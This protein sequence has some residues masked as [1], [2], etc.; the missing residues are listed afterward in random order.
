MYGVDDFELGTKFDLPKFHTVNEEGKFISG[1]G[2]LEGR[3]VKEVD[4]NGKPT[5]AVDIVNDLT[6]RGLLFKKENYLHS[7]PHCW[8]CDTP[9]LYYARTSWYF[10]MSKLRDQLVAANQE[11]NWEP[12]HVKEGRFGEWLDGIKDW[13]ISRDRYWGTPLPVWS[14]ESGK[15]VVI[16]GLDDLKKYIKKSGNSYFM[17]RHGESEK[18]T[19]DLCSSNPDAP[20]PL[21]EKGRS[22]AKQT[23]LGLVDSRITK[24]IASPFVRTRETAEIVADILGISKE[25]IVYDPSIGELH[26]GDFDGKSKS[27]YHAWHKESNAGFSTQIP[28]G[29]SI[30]EARNR[31]GQ[32]LYRIDKQY[33]NEN[34]LIVTHGIFLESM[35]S[36]VGG[37]DEEETMRRWK[38]DIQSPG[39]CKKYDFVPLPHNENYALDFHKPYIDE[40][41]LE[42][43]GESLKRTPEVMDVWFDSG[44]MPIAQNHELGGDVNFDP[45]PA[46]YIAEGMD[47]TRGWFYTMHAISNMLH[48]KPSVAYKN[49]ICMGLLMDAN[50]QKMSKSKGN[51]VDPW[52]MFDKYG[53]DVVRFWFYSVNQPGETKN[54]DEKGLD[55]VNKK[56]FNLLRNVVAFYEMFGTEED[57]ATGGEHN[58]YSSP[59]VLDIWILAKL[60]ELNKIATKG[61]DTYQPLEPARALR[62]FIGELSTWY[63]RR[64]RDRFKSDDISDRRFALRTTQ[65]VLRNLSLMMAPFTPFVAEEVFQ[66]TK[67]SG[68]PESVHLGVWI[69]RSGADFDYGNI[70]ADM[71]HVRNLVTLGLE[72]RQK[73]NVKVRQPLSKLLINNPVKFKSLVENGSYWEEYKMIILEELNIKEVVIFY[74]GNEQTESLNPDFVSIDSFVTQDLKDEGDMRELVRKIQDM[75]KEAG[76]EPKDRVKVSLAGNEPAWFGKFKPEISQ[77]VGAESISWGGEDGVEKVS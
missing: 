69:D 52:T 33:S 4:E 65:L 22:D 34:I 46:D 67:W 15:R 26:Y 10:G 38:E 49:A 72:A 13:A 73:A 32:A 19:R 53:A 51:V 57:L 1:T 68:D 5:L 37:W 41:E 39:T 60:D 40:V 50:G 12:D 59:N 45:A 71:D 35:P 30:K 36:L 16:G 21:T 17:M 70:L 66:K 3:Y 6:A 63:I 75:R 54:F 25:E 47:Q 42:L 27:E 44:C 77:T 9:L 29:E 24:I 11:I 31:V 8:R 20:L 61:L 62:E 56:V 74:P 48:D 55:E 64:S 43:D 58:P 76:L 18:N 2:F 28:G 23:A 7:Y 14:T